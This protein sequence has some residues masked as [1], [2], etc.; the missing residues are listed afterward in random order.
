[1][2]I[3]SCART[4]GND[5]LYMTHTVHI[6]VPGETIACASLADIQD[7][8]PRYQR[9][10]TRRQIGAYGLALA[11]S[12][13]VRPTTGFE[14]ATHVLDEMARAKASLDIASGHCI[15]VVQATAS[16]MLATQTYADEQTVPCTEWPLP[17]E[18]ADAARQAAEQAVASLL[19]T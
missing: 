9:P 14:D 16:V 12:L 10:E 3:L 6:Q 8:I 1:M 5:T 11:A 15:D 2:C 17:K 7:L 13:A 19:S 18:V 4:V